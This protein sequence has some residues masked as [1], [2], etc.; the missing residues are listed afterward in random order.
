MFVFLSEY[1]RL[2]LSIR[3]QPTLLGF[4]HEGE[5]ESITANRCR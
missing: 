4:L 2:V 5:A 3:L 1:A